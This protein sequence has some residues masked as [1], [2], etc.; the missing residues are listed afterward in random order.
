MWM[1][2]CECVYRCKKKRAIYQCIFLL[3]FQYIWCTEYF[4]WNCTIFDLS[5]LKNVLFHNKADLF[6]L[7]YFTYFLLF[8]FL[9]YFY[10][11]RWCWE[12]MI[13]SFK[14]F[15]SNM[16][17]HYRSKQ[18]TVFEWV[19]EFTWFKTEICSRTRVSQW[20]FY[21]TYSLRMGVVCH[22][23]CRCKNTPNKGEYFINNVSNSILTYCLSNCRIKIRPH[24]QC[25]LFASIL[26]R[27]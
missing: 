19:I 26:V 3:H 2:I 8:T 16:L 20:I 27:L 14:L 13:E 15:R 25:M 6:I 11:N 12:W 5:C 23:P 9:I 21:S 4:L 24:L 18:M 10:A 1:C 17:I 7:T 22:F